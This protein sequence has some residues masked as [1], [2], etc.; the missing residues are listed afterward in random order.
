MPVLSVLLGVFFVLVVLVDA[1]ETVVLPRT[2]KRTVRLS[3][4]FFQIAGRI[5]LG[6]GKI[7]PSGVRQGLLVA[8]A[9]LILL[10][11]ISLW[12]LLMVIGW[13]LIHFGIGTPLG[14][15][16]LGSGDNSLATDLYFSGV[17]FLTLGYG[18]V[19]PMNALGRLLAVFEAGLGFGFLALVVSYVPVLYS[20][21]SRRE[22]QILLLDSRAGSNPI[23]A[24]LIRRYSVA[25]CLTQVI[26]VLRD[27][28]RFGAEL[29]ESYLSYPLLAYYRSQH[30]NQSWLKSLIAIMDACTLIEVGFESSKGQ[31]N[32]LRFQARATFA[33]ARHVLVDLS[34]ILD[35]PPLPTS[36]YRLRR[37]DIEDFRRSLKEVG[38]ELR[39]GEEADERFLAYFELYE[40]YAQGLSS[41]LLLELPSL[42]VSVKDLDNWQTSAWDTR[43]HF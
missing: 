17:T 14:S 43:R 42:R 28:E 9:P 27:W 25:G 22:V 7:R 18:D 12:A 8:F 40:P 5:Y 32:D 35:V 2:V 20:S 30:D 16:P 1:F 37:E 11:L 31:D 33:M 29:L 34:Y 41:E 6:I 21:F 10:I 24:E 4:A 15:T 26:P 13:G 3:N 38:I 23:G 19:V 39:S 36:S